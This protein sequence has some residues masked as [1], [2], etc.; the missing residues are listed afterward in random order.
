MVNENLS[1]S[2]R[3]HLNRS[4]GFI[5]VACFARKTHPV[6]LCIELDNPCDPR[7]SPQYESV[8]QCPFCYYI[9]EKNEFKNDAIKFTGSADK[10]KFA[11]DTLKINGVPAHAFSVNKNDQDLG[12]HGPEIE[13]G[14]IKLCLNGLSEKLQATARETLKVVGF[15]EK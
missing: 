8:N 10:L 1:H 9:P 13:Q 11:V 4:D 15:S 6:D 5:I 3:G 14:I 7:E 12:N 2:C